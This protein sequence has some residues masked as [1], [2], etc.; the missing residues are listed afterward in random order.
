M[1]FMSQ[2]IENNFEEV[3]PLAG[4]W[5]EILSTTK[6]SIGVKSLPSRERG[7]KLQSS[8]FVPDHGIVAPLAGA[9]IE[10]TVCSFESELECVAPL[11]GAW[12]EILCPPH[13]V[14]SDKRRSP[15]GSVD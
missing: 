5:I 11:A 8:V 7:L 13:T 2:E 15:R 3:A 1:K 6:I 12:I 14:C 10:I 4:A 9:W